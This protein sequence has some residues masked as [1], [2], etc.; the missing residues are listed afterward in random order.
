MI[1][2]KLKNAHLWM[3]GIVTSKDGEECVELN[4]GGREAQS[5]EGIM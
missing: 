3:C 5:K 4:V 2:L 1:S